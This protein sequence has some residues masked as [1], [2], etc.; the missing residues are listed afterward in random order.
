MKRQ[1]TLARRPS[2]AVKP[3]SNGLFRDLRE[4]ILAT[5][6][7]VARGINSALVLL[8]WK[9]GERIHSE[10]LKER[11]AEYGKEILPT[12]SAKLVPEFGQGFS[13]RNLA[14]MISLAEAFPSPEIL[15]TLSRELGW[16]HFV[17]LL[18]LTKPLQRD[19]YAEMCRVERWSV[20]TL[21]EKIAGMLYERTALSKKPPEL[22]A[23]ELKQLRDEDKMTPDLVFRDSYLLDFLGLQGAYSEKDLESAI[24]RDLETFLVELGGDFAF[25]A[26]QKRIV[27]DDED[28][29]LDLLFYHRRLRRL[30][31]IELKLGKFAPADV[32]QM[33]FYLRWLKKHEM[34]S[35]EEEPLGLILC[36]EKSDE[37]IELFELATR[38]IRV[39]EY[40]TE[41]PPRKILERKLHA[42]VR[43]AQARLQATRRS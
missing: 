31:A 18:P 6:Q 36:A 34:R 40:L 4:M 14:R 23:V 3:R 32:G 30:V 10:I 5:R 12:L 22:A 8:Y 39:S 27:V 15:S 26:R 1:R 37:R 19:F 33:E 41:L 21:R 42:A 17:E 38:G 35:G 24:L 2:A 7:T 11:R 25:L 28:F 13:P 43:L 20:R 16:S 9:V 29:F